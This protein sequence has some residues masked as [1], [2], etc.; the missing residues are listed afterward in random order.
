MRTEDL[1]KFGNVWVYCSQH[2][3][4]H[5]TGWCTVG[6]EHKTVL[7][8]GEKNQ[9]EAMD[10]CRELGFKLFVDDEQ[11]RNIK[12]AVELKTSDEVEVK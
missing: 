8:S 7:C 12:N 11:M 5:K 6:L 3:S 4:A 2:R 10:I 1:K 9:D